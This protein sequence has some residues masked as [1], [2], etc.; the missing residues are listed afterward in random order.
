MSSLLLQILMHALMLSAV[1]ILLPLQ[2]DIPVTT[3][4]ATALQELLPVSS[5]HSLLQLSC[6]WYTWHDQM[7]A[8]LGL[9]GFRQPPV[10]HGSWEKTAGRAMVITPSALPETV[11]VRLVCFAA[12]TPQRARLSGTSS[13]CF[14]SWMLLTRQGSCD[15]SLGPPAC[16][17]A[18]LQ[19]STPG[20]FLL[21]STRRHSCTILR[22]SA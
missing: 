22:S 13:R 3:L 6:V 1:N 11:I 18:A 17:L 21:G 2:F 12:D 19:P 10:Q 5:H 16:R 14:Q 9:Q 8:K 4:N 15:L 20:D 7:V